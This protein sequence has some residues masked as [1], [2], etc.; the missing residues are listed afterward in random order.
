MHSPYIRPLS[1]LLPMY[2]P[3]TIRAFALIAIILC[4]LGLVGSG[5]MMMRAN[6]I[7]FLGVLSWAILL[8]AS[9]IGFQLSKY[10]LQDEEYRKVGL[11]IYLIIAAFAV[12]IFA[13]VLVG[14]IVAVALLSTLW[15]MKK[16]YDEWDNKTTR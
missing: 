15:A 5:I 7:F 11:R 16:N 14:L 3:K 8:W 6:G 2:K 9:I 13:S 10:P 1:F 4:L 12:F